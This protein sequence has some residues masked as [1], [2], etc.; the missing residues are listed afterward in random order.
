MDKG[1]DHSLVLYQEVAAQ[2]EQAIMRGKWVPGQKLPALA[3]L[4]A[5][6]QVSRAVIREACTV[7]VGAGLV[8]LRH[9]DGTYVRSFSLD[10]FL[11][12]MHAALLLGQADVRSLLEVGSW[13]ERGMAQTAAH[14]RTDEQCARLLD[15]LFA[16]EV[17]RGNVDAM[18]EAERS[19]HFAV[20]AAADNDMGANLMRILYQPLAGVLRHLLLQTDCEEEWLSVHRALY[21][22]IL[23]MDAV[24]AVR[25]MTLYREMQG[26]RI[27]RMREYPLSGRDD[28]L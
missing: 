25:Q 8:E 15:A 6:F 4:A 14:K 23:Q 9:G 7:L 27:R 3:E 21:D 11:R 16:M 24:A 2:I 13:L 5:H 28:Q 19:F 22:S 1:A 26:E 10:H 20:A 12:P 18:L 17:G